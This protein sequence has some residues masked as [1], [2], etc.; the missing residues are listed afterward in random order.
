MLRNDKVA[1]EEG[2]RN[3][4]MAFVAD[5][6]E[7]SGFRCCCCAAVFSFLFRARAIIS[8]A[9]GEIA[10]A[11]QHARFS[12][13]LL[14]LLAPQL[15]AFKANGKSRSERH[16]VVRLLFYRR[17]TRRSSILSPLFSLLQL[18]PAADV[19]GETPIAVPALRI[20]E[21]TLKNA[22]I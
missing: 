9:A 6:G 19:L 20:L 18:G 2:S 16:S 13:P 15:A 21:P 1:G 7:L 22:H 12:L 14:S 3:S 5:L 11:W 10:P 17:F 4:T 8:P